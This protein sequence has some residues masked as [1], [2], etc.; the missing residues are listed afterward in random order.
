MSSPFS[1][2]KNRRNSRSFKS[3]NPYVNSSRPI[4]RSMLRNLRRG[5]SGRP[6]C[7]PPRPPPPRLGGRWRWADGNPN[8]G[9]Q[10]RLHLYH[11]RQCLGIRE[12]DW[13][14]TVSGQRALF[15]ISQFWEHLL[16]QLSSPGTLLL[17]PVS[18]QSPRLQESAPEEGEPSHVL[19]R[20]LPQHRHP[21]EEG[22]SHTS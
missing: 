7:L 18:G 12:R 22:W 6:G 21:E 20:P 10:T 5:V 9:L 8:D 13:S 1:R 4:L 15:W 19:G 16:L 11:G 14:R 17:S 2:T 3:N